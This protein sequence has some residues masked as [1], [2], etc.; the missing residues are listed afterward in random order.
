MKENDNNNELMQLHHK[1]L[2][3]NHIHVQY[4]IGTYSTLVYPVSYTH[5]AIS[6]IVV[7]ILH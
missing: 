3:Q 1:H 2:E 6:L 4:I 5:H 7:L